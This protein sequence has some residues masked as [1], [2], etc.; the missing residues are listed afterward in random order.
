M[1]SRGTRGRPGGTVGP[2]AGYSSVDRRGAAGASRWTA[3]CPALGS[4]VSRGSMVG[5]AFEIV[6]CPRCTTAS[7][8]VGVRSLAKHRAVEDDAPSGESGSAHGAP[9]VMV[10]GPVIGH[11]SILVGRAVHRDRSC[12]SLRWRKMRCSRHVPGHLARCP[13]QARAPGTPRDHEAR[14]RHAIGNAR[15]TMAMLAPAYRPRR[16]TETVLYRVVRAHL[17]TFLQHARE[18]YEAPLPRY[19]EREL[20]GYLRCGVFAHGFV[21]ARC[22]ECDHD[23][24]VAFSCK[25]RGVLPQLRWETYGE[26][27]CAPRRSR[28]S[29]GRGAAMG[30]V[31]AIRATQARGVRRARARGARA[32][33]RRGAG[34]SLPGVGEAR[35]ARRGAGAAPSRSFNDS[36]RV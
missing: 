4:L 26:Y 5:R 14:R 1:A 13:G 28:A 23:L 29:R 34:G 24:L 12:I 35:S 16:P 8:D 30:A 9:A 33:F 6:A 31:V 25:G 22:D 17:A 7:L 2:F 19:V 32:T 36:A 18:T 21:R 3:W 11:R 15:R 27:G 20:R 10:Q